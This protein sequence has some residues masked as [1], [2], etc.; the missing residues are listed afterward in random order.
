MDLIGANSTS[1]RS[2]HRVVMFETKESKSK[3]F[4]LKLVNSILFYVLLFE[5]MYELGILHVTNLCC[6]SFQGIISVAA[7][8]GCKVVPTRPFGG[9]DSINQYS[10]I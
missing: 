10:F 1:H 8:G 5:L 7:R 9:A 2:N 3:T 6:I 4:R